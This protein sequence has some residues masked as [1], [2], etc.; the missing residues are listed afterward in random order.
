MQLIEYAMPEFRNNYQAEKWY[1]Q[2]QR[3]L[4]FK[5]HLSY[6]HLILVLKH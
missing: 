4:A 6:F 1:H 5:L 2:C 3:S